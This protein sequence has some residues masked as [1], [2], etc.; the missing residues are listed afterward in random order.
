MEDAPRPEEQV[1]PAAA[2]AIADEGEA[3]F[4]AAATPGPRF[5]RHIDCLYFSFMLPSA[6][7][8]WDTSSTS[9]AKHSSASSWEE[10]TRGV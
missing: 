8:P 6:R 10:D 9:S 5:D 2:A 4:A 7:E 1:T 3:A